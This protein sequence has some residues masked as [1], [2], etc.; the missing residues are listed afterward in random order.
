MGAMESLQKTYHP[1]QYIGLLG[2]TDSGPVGQ[3]S[4]QSKT[5]SEPLLLS[6]DLF[7]A[8]SSLL[9][10]SVQTKKNGFCVEKQKTWI[11]SFFESSLRKMVVYIV[12]FLLGLKI[13]Y[14]VLTKEKKTASI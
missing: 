6:P 8:W 10:I 14:V 5:N 7:A 4:L 2:A 11:C 9:G 3:G 12:S 1:I 13:A